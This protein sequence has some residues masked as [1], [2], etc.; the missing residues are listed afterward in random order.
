MRWN[1]LRA[2][3]NHSRLNPGMPVTQPPQAQATSA[4]TSPECGCV[5]GR[6]TRPHHRRFCAIVDTTRRTGSRQRTTLRTLMITEFQRYL[7]H[8]GH[9]RRADLVDELLL[10]QPDEESDVGRLRQLIEDEDQRQEQRRRDGLDE[11]E[12]ASGEYRPD[13]PLQ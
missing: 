3:M 12:E 4:T 11:D 10:I 13:F 1:L 2:V 5:Y 9:S 7:R 8:R 6:R